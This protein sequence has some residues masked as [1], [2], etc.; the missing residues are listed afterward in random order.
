MT[1]AH[2]HVERGRFVNA[3][4]CTC[5]LNIKARTISLAHVFTRMYVAVRVTTNKLIKHTYIISAGVYRAVGAATAC[6]G[7]RLPWRH[8]PRTP[9]LA[10]FQ[11]TRRPLVTTRQRRP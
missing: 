7:A 2:K 1:R 5:F 8:P 9:G 11:L 6:C 3:A 4:P 10:R